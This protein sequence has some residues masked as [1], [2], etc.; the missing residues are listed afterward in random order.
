MRFGQ[1]PVMDR[2]FDRIFI[3]MLENELES[4]VLQ[5]DYMRDR[6]PVASG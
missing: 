3:I 5:D 6:N 2:V 4:A 1:A